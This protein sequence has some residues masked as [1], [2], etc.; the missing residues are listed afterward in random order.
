MCV[1]S[2]IGCADPEAPTNGWVERN[3]DVAVVRCN[4]TSHTWELRC[5]D[6]A[7]KGDIFTECPP[8]GYIYHTVQHGNFS[9][10]YFAINL[11][12]IQ[13]NFIR[14]QFSQTRLLLMC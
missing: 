2:A 9:G 11:N 10:K 3:D 4:G 12:K 7:W 6:S 13:L 8:D 1:L 14:L 5:H